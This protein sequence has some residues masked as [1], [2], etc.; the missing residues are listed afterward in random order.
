MYFMFSIG[1]NFSSFISLRMIFLR[2]PTIFPSSL[3]QNIEKINIR[4]ISYKPN[5][6]SVIDQLSQYLE[7]GDDYAPLRLMAKLVGKKR[8]EDL[9]IENNFLQKI[10]Y[11]GWIIGPISG[12]IV[13]FAL[14]LLI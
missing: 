1:M 7:S 13:G 8:K 9:L 10:K 3:K 12:A 14:S 4:I 11:W 5:S 2:C 6:N